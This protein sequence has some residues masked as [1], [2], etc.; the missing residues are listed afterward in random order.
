MV[1]LKLLVQISSSPPTPPSSIALSS[2]CDCCDIAVLLLFSL[3]NIE[4][5]RQMSSPNEMSSNFQF[6]ALAIGDESVL[7][8]PCV[9]CG[10]RTGRY[11][12]GLSGEEDCMAAERVPSEIWAAGQHTP[13]CSRCEKDL[14]ACRFCRGVHGCSG[15]PCTK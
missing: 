15:I 13:L 5:D 10:L 2:I 6:E 11:C 14:R 7:C 1:W 3:Y 9:E 12:E 8:R 4:R